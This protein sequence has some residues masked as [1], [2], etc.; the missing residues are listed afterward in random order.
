MRPKPNFK[1]GCKLPG[2]FSHA[3]SQKIFHHLHD[4]D[5]DPAGM[6]SYVDYSP[7]LPRHIKEIA[8]AAG[9]PIP[10]EVRWPELARGLWKAFCMA[11]AQRK[12]DSAAKVA[13]SGAFRELA[14]CGR[15]FFSLLQVEVADLRDGGTSGELVM[16]DTRV[17]LPLA[18]Q[19][20][21]NVIVP[22]LHGLR[23]I[24][25]AAEAVKVK[26][27]PATNNFALRLLEELALQFRDAFG[28]WP[29]VKKD[30]ERDPNRP[31]A[32]WL[33]E[34][35]KHAMS[36]GPPLDEP[37]P[38]QNSLTVESESMAH[39]L[40]DTFGIWP[41]VKNKNQVPDPN[42][43]AARGPRKEIKCAIPTRLF[44]MLPKQNAL[45]VEL[46]PI[47][48]WKTQTLLGKFEEAVSRAKRRY[49]ADH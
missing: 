13:R 36:A 2:N 11:L 10:P 31:A 21:A 32:R 15:R 48:R 26:P 1:S 23:A 46:E 42:S 47:N 9:L 19:L 8:E 12:E 5:R 6:F 37:P 35:I 28:C 3:S 45:A 40:H 22:T 41:A 4:F 30:R 29:V 20:G 33:R 34:V 27:G 17:I 49:S 24:V 16:N 44:E 43:P 38:I 39:A 7:F 25:T 14:A 18:R